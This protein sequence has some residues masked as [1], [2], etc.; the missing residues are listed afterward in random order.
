MRDLRARAGRSPPLQC[1]GIVRD[2]WRDALPCVR[3]A[4]SACV[5]HGV[6]VGLSMG[7]PCAI[8]ARGLDWSPPLQCAG[9]VR[10]VWRDALQCVRCVGCACAV[11]GQSVG[12]SMDWLCAF[13][14]LRYTFLFPPSTVHDPTR[15]VV[16]RPRRSMSRRRHEGGRSPQSGD[17]SPQ[18]ISVCGGF[19]VRRLESPLWDCA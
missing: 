3:C 2:A 7:F 17:I 12:L 6:A 9:I 4:G 11:H 15:W 1:A 5:V 13:H 14:V 19:G 18:S 10:D 16:R 8:Y